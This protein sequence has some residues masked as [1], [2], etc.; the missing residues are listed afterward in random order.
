MAHLWS[1]QIDHAWVPIPLDAD[2]FDLATAAPMAMAAS[3]VTS[4]LTSSAMLRRAGEGTSAVWAL[5]A[6]PDAAVLV[7]GTAARLGV[8]VLSDRDEIRLPDAAPLYF[9]LEQLAEI[10]PFPAGGRG[11]CPRC[12]DPLDPGAPAVACPGCG[13]W[14]HQSE[15]RTCWTSGER[16]NACAHLTTLDTGFQWTPEEL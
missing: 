5:L 11:F 4:L 16:C 14:H 3:A 6:H 8:V 9:S 7:N 10:V 13:L 15:K 12:K 2:L 1:Q